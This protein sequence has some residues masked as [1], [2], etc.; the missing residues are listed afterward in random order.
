[1]ETH[2]ECPSVLLESVAVHRPG[3]SGPQPLEQVTLVACVMSSQCMR[4]RPRQ[5][6]LEALRKDG[7]DRVIGGRQGYV[8]CAFYST[9]ILSTLSFREEVLERSQVERRLGTTM[10][11][12]LNVHTLQQKTRESHERDEGIL[13]K[14]KSSTGRG[15]T[16]ATYWSCGGRGTCFL[17]SVHFSVHW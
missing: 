16:R 15:G 9:Y 5:K 4:Q 13:S 11:S 12:R 7:Y 6:G 2:S 14:C 17:W 3:K 1:M 10:T 8:S